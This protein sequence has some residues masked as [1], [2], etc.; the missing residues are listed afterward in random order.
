M[1][2]SILH[3]LGRLTPTHRLLVG[4]AL[5][6]LAWGLAPAS[7]G[8]LGRLVAAWDVYAGSTLLLIAALV[9]TADA[10]HIRRIAT[11]ED[12]SRALA[13]A[14]ILGASLASLLAVLALSRTVHDLAPAET[15]WRV[16]L[17]IGAVVEA[18]LLVHTVFTLRYAHQYYDDSGPGGQD[19]RGIDFPGQDFEPDYLDFAYFAFTIGMAAQTADV[20]ISGR[21]PRRTALLH[22]LISFSFNTA[23]VALSISA[24][25]GLLR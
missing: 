22:S 4:L 19:A 11:A 9:A 12:N 10:G 21:L 25:G 8:T 3:H 13:S 7:L 18:W 20:S 6:A 5:G 17:S 1:K 15:A 24:L 23:I 14:F 16:G 2:S